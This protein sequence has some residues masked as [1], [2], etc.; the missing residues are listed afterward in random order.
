MCMENDKIHT[1]LHQFLNSTTC[2]ADQASISEFVDSPIYDREK[3]KV[4]LYLKQI[5]IK[6][7]KHCN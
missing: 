4:N 1:K 5:Y 6:D 7:P 3:S 2:N